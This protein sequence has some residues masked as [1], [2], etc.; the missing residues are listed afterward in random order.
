MQIYILAARFVFPYKVNEYGLELPRETMRETIFCA[1]SKNEA[2]LAAIRFTHQLF[3]TDGPF[4]RYS[5]V[6]A[7]SVHAFEV[8]PITPLGYTDN[9]RLEPVLEWKRDTGLY[10][11]KNASDDLLSELSDLRKLT[12]A[13]WTK[14]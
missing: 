13:N 2:A 3:V 5:Q 14:W 6:G 8:M 11:P 9:R 10:T 12:P 1:G 7:L 4:L